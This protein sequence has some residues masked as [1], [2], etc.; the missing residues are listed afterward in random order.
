MF[1]GIIEEIGIIE[2]IQSIGEGIRLS[3]SAPRSSAELK[4]NDSVSV[5]GVCQ[6]V[7]GCTA[8]IF[9]VEAVEET[10]KKTTLGSLK[11]NDKVNLELPMRL[12][13][14]LG[15]HLVLGHVDSV[16][17]VTDIE[18]RE[19]SW[20]VTVKIPEKFLRYTVPV[21]S[22]AIDGVSLTIAELDGNCVKVS[23]IP[24]TWENTIFQ[25]YKIE[26]GVN[27]EFDIIG[28]YIERMMN[29]GNDM[30]GEKKTLSEQHL[31]EL[32]Y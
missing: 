26:T 30:K 9:T 15:G 4:I 21:G 2:R 6:T 8:G 5:N 20:L 10:L 32:G 29:N 13:E 7:I 17:K 25:N 16:G 12:N 3:L 14:R 24:H 28:K 19:N 22:I 23:I 31:R 18:P 1:T 27:L 11:I